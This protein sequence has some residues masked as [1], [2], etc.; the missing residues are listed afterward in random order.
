MRE[1]AVSHTAEQETHTNLI[2]KC[3][4]NRSIVRPGRRWK[5]NIKTDL[6]KTKKQ[7]TDWI[8]VAY[9]RI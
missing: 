3:Q 8:Q 9:D 6:Q 2:R 5:D 1:Y 4:L 7:G